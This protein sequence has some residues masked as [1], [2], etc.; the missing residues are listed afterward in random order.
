MFCCGM[1]GTGKYVAVLA[2]MG[3]GITGGCGLN[4]FRG[5]IMGGGFT[6]GFRGEGTLCGEWA[7]RTCVW[8]GMLI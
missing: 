4:N 3:D 5:G 6:S 7:V 1:L 2:G 8:C